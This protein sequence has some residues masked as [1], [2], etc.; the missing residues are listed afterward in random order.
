MNVRL[1]ANNVILAYFVIGTPIFLQLDCKNKDLKHRYDNLSV[2]APVTTRSLTFLLL[3]QRPMLLEE[4]IVHAAVNFRSLL[5][6]KLF[7]SKLIPLGPQG[8][9]L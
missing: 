4:T 6:I 2:C 8:V 5:L 7:C 9:F 1:L 3:F